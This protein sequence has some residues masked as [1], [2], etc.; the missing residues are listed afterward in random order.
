MKKFGKKRGRPAAPRG[1]I[2]L[3]SFME[4]NINALRSAGRVRTSEIYASALASFKRFTDGHDVPLC[5]LSQEMMGAYEGYLKERGLTRNSTSCYMRALRAVYNRAVDGQV[6]QTR[7]PFRRVYTGV[8]KTTKRA[9]PLEAIRRIKEMDLG[10][11]RG[12]DYARDM[13][14]FSFYTRG[15]SFVDM[16][17]LRKR[18]LAGGILAYRRRKTGQLLQ[19]RWEPCMQAIVDK[20][21]GRRRSPYIL[22]IIADMTRDERTQYRSANCLV[23]RRLKLIGRSIGLPHPLT[24]YVARH[25]WATAAKACDIPLPLI[26]AGMGHESENTTRI[27]LSTVDTGAVDAANRLVL[28]SLR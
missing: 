9:I 14:L 3:T 21:P 24:M 4:M 28:G 23:N 8:E 18:D 27:Y 10:G 12:L 22:P 17:Y 25:S 19:V 15:M 2:S 7:H 20:Y 26:S 6:V 5:R 1:G 11:S 16:A 13:F